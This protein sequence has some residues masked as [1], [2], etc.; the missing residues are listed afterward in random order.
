MPGMEEG[1]VP[2]AQSGEGAQAPQGGAG[3]ELVSGIF[4][5]IGTLLEALQG[6]GMQAEAQ[7]L[8]QLQ[9]GFQQ[10]VE[11]LGQAGAGG[12]EQAQGVTTPEAGT[13]DVRPVA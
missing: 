5:D 9:Q 1:Q 4:E 3:R 10:F 13:A 2:Q 8:A 6:S 11:K 12:A 7:E